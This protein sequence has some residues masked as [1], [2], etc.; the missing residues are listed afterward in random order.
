MEIGSLSTRLIP[1]FSVSS[2]PVLSHYPLSTGTDLGM[3]VLLTWS[4]G[5]KWQAWVAFV[6]CE[7]Q[8]RS[9]QT[10]AG[11]LF[12]RGSLPFA[13][14]GGFSCPMHQFKFGAFQTLS[15]LREFFALQDMFPVT[16]KKKIDIQVHISAHWVFKFNSSLFYLTCCP[17]EQKPFKKSSQTS[18]FLL[19]LTWEYGQLSLEHFP[20]RKNWQTGIWKDKEG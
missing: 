3:I 9:L 4:A 5:L 20:R 15:S 6:I 7:F 14:G 17:R 1:N 18:A 12:I 2:D 11:R 10:I 16:L 13:W 8:F 19:T